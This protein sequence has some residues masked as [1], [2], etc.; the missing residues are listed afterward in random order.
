MI[1]ATLA[2]VVLAAPL[3][4]DAQQL[5]KAARI[6]FLG[7]ATAVPAYIEAFRQGL[8]D[9]G[10]VEGQNITIEFREAGGRPERLPDLAAELL[11]LKVDVLVAR[12]T[13]A[14]LAA[15][16]ATSTIPIVM[17]ASSDPVGTGLVA[18]LARP[19][20]NITGLSFI[21]PELSGKRLELL[22]E[23]HPGASRVAV[24]W[25]PADPPRA[26][27]LRETEAAARMLGVTLL[28]WEVRGPDDLE[29]AFVAMARR[30]AGAVITFAD[31]IT[32]AHRKRIVDLVAKHRLPGMYGTRAFVE[33]GGLMSY[34]ANLPDLFRR[35]A[36][37]VDKI[38]K[39][40][41]P[42]DLP[43]EQPTRFELVINLKT[44]KALGLTIPQSILIRAEEVIR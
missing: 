14:I 6:G 16:Q 3:T 20:G 28:S 10:Y 5:A 24:L 39:G 37:Y 35:S 15:K 33:A 1:V 9:L 31:P 23:V 22:K 21:S 26:L 17:A 34:G 41:K 40:T 18:S 13:Q 8:R 42:A 38:L 7:T 4:A 25:N 2:L 12:G 29:G 32:T 19:G 44:A 27:E 11:R 43:V 36:A 30:R